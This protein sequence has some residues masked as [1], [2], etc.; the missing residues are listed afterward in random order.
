MAHSSMGFQEK[1]GGGQGCSS[2][3]SSLPS[4]YTVYIQVYMYACSEETLLREMFCLGSHLSTEQLESKSDG[5]VQSQVVESAFLS[6]RTR[7]NCKVWTLNAIYF[8]PACLFDCTV[9]QRRQQ[10]QRSGPIDLERT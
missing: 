4:V 2:A 10:Q 5:K 6:L 3:D 1:T 9:R 7:Q 8:L